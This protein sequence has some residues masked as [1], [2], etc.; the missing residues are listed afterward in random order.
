[1]SAPLYA[2]LGAALIGVGL[3]GVL[4]RRHLF[5]RI[6]ALNVIGSGIFLLFVTGATPPD[7]VPQAF[8]LTGIVVTVAATALALALALRVAV[9]SGR[10]S[11]PE[12]EPV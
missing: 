10:T 9:Q 11:L 12:D 4:L 8:V 3:Y 2:L 6:I 5:R 1:V 7:P